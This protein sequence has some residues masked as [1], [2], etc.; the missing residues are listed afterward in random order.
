MTSESKRKK[1]QEL[2]CSE[3]GTHNC[4]RQE[5]QY[6]DFCLT[7]NIRPE[8]LEKVTDQYRGEGLDAR[9]ARASA[10][11][12]GVY[13]GKLTRVEEI[14]AFANRLGVK[15]IGLATCIGLAEEARI[16]A[17]ILKVNGLEPY[18]VLCKI[19]SVDKNDIGI[20]DSL[21]IQK[22]TH[23]AICNP[24]LQAKQ[25]NDH[26]T[27]LNVVIGLCVGHDSLFIKHSD[28]P[29]TTLITKDRVLGHNPAA[30]LYTSGFYYKR[31]FEAGRN[32]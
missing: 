22:G 9:I 23:E 7:E 28:A 12:E 6:P 25:L 16:F 2:S 19:G 17:K 21:K 18:S 20:D 10:E 13:Y 11:V 32:L 31:L 3:C 26:K 8:E 4:Y 1:K 5:R 29:V 30:A 27:E 15:N 24:I 14:I